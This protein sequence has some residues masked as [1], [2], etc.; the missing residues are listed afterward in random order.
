M[1]NGSDPVDYT[2]GALYITLNVA[3]NLTMGIVDGL[4]FMLEL[5]DLQAVAV[6]MIGILEI[7]VVVGIVLGPGEIMT[8]L[9][10][11]GTI[12]GTAVSAFMAVYALGSSAATALGDGTIYEKARTYGRN[13]IILLGSAI[14]LKGISFAGKLLGN[15]GSLKNLFSQL[16]KI[17][18]EIIQKSPQFLRIL[19]LEDV[20][21]AAALL[22]ER[23]AAACGTSSS[24]RLRKK[25]GRLLNDLKADFS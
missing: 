20:P 14:S 24:T 7:S 3:Y 23:M 4:Q 18:F 17:S 22:K 13:A 10:T 6:T 12:L 19:V 8:V 16:G 15:E 25:L 5:P 11:I 2:N 1:A 9:S 21:Q